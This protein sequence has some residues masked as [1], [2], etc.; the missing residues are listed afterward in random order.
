M[1]A[2]QTLDRRAFLKNSAAGG[3][4]LLIGFYLPAYAGVDPAAAQEK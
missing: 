4:G 3:A 2:S 1:T